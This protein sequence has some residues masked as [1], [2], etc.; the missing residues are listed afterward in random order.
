MDP[1]RLLQL[2]QICYLTHKWLLVCSHYPLQEFLK[3]RSTVYSCFRGA[4]VSLWWSLTIKLSKLVTWYCYVAVVLGFCW[5]FFPLQNKWFSV[6]TKISETSLFA[7]N[8]NIVQYGSNINIHAHEYIF[9]VCNMVF[10][11][12]AHWHTAMLAEGEGPTWKCSKLC[13]TMPKGESGGRC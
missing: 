2:T 10:P 8:N 11:A 7:Q 4:S 12:C 6:V 1:N 13:P 5:G 3:L 9:Q